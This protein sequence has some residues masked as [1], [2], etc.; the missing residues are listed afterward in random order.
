[1]V[2]FFE[3]RMRGVAHVHGHPHEVVIA[4]QRALHLPLALPPALLLRGECRRR[5][6]GARGRNA[7]L[8]VA[9]VAFHLVNM[10]TDC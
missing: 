5:H 6:G 9:L 1:M 7:A 4:G 10:A 8:A 2:L 3:E